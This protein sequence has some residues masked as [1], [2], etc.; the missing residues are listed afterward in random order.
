MN[1]L[2]HQLSY[3]LGD[4]LPPGGTTLELAP[5]VR[6]LRMPLPFALDHINLWLLR[7]RDDAGRDG[8]AIVDCGIT[9]D[10]T[11]AAWEQV[12]ANEMEGLPVL[13]VIVT[14]MHPDHIGLAH[15]LTEHW[16]VRLWISATDWNA[17]RMAS[18]ATTGFGGASAAAFMASHGLADPDALEKIRA[19][20]NYYASMVPKVPG[21]F[22]RLMHGDVLRIGAH[23]WQ[24]HAGYGHAPEHIAL[25]NEALGLLISGDMVL[26]RI[27]T[28][29]SVIDIEPE[30]NPLP[31]YLASIERMRALP[32]DTLVLPSHGKP[33]RGLHQRVDQLKTH[34]DDRFAEVIAACAIEPQTA[35]SLLP[36][37]FKR[38]L[39][40]HQTT[41]AMGESIAHLHALWL[42]GRL[43]RQTAADGVQ[44]FVPA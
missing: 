22:R 33:F 16:G 4:A 44:R 23:D 34:H 12:F 17:A 37:L 32:A 26:P 5:G 11:R 13:R 30:A 21:A 43:R 2:E 14:H 39:D 15:W 19:R 31:L 9:S 35:A 29:V 27:S 41:F 40:L 38:K 7:D 28:N 25:H 3:P 6:W 36:V 20:T 42:G 1:E 24:C 8:W 18:Q 10:T